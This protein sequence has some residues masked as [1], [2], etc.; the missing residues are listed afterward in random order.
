MRVVSLLSFCVSED[1]AE[2]DSSHGGV[3]HDEKERAD[4]AVN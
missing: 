1:A 3:G 4:T 2:R